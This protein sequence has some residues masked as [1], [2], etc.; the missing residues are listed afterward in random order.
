M[1]KLAETPVSGLNAEN[2]NYPVGLWL[3]ALFTFHI[4]LLCCVFGCPL[5]ETPFWV[6]TLTTLWVLA[7]SVWCSSFQP[8]LQL[9]WDMWPG[10]HQWHAA[11]PDFGSVVS[12]AKKKGQKKSHF[13]S[14]YNSGGSG[15]AHWL[16]WS[17]S[18]AWLLRPGVGKFFSVKGLTVN[19]S[20]SVGHTVFVGTI[21]F[22]CCS[23]KVA[24]D[25]VW[26]WL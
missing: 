4:A 19:I 12:F 13:V 10:L 1:V 25:H 16:Y 6:W 20:G 18:W 21:Q 8:P 26:I 7:E 14:D 22:C 24:I 9:V 11:A 5:S 23:L 2:N 3:M 17:H 15:G